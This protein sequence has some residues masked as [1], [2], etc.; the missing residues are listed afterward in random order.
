MSIEKYLKY[1]FEEIEQI[2]EISENDNSYQQRKLMIVHLKIP[3]K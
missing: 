3:K 2:E 1:R